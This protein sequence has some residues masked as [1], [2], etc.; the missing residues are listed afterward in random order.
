MNIIRKIYIH[1]L[2]D[3][4]VPRAF[5]RLLFPDVYTK[6]KEHRNLLA[7]EHEVCHEAE[8]LPTTCRF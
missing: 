6:C 8:V 2:D 4:L 5:H 7:W 1:L 3:R